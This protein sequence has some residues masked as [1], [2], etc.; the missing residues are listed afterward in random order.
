M[1]PSFLAYAVCFAY[2][3]FF[4]LQ[5]ALIVRNLLVVV[6]FLSLAA[7]RG[8]TVVAHR[9]GRNLSFGLYAAI[10]VLLAANF[11]WEVYAAR[12]IR[13]RN[14]PEYFLQKFREYAE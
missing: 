10:G 11:G 4:S 3:G 14:H 8:I 2:P 1:P 12:Q 7:A 6:P 9:F 13:L 5:S